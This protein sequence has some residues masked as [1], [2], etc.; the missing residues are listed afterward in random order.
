M[1]ILDVKSLLS[2]L[3]PCDISIGY[4]SAFLK[5]ENRA[6][7]S[8][9]LLD[10]LVLARDKNEFVKDLY[11]TK[12]ISSGSMYFSQ[13]FDQEVAFFADLRLS[14]SQR[15]KVGVIE[16]SRALRRMTEWDGSF[17]I[18][19]RL[20]KPVRLLRCED[21]RIERDFEFARARNFES[22]L[23]AAVIL[24]R[25]RGSDLFTSFDLLTVLVSMSYLGDIRVSF[26]EDPRKV[27]NIVA[28]QGEDLRSMY[29]PFFEKVGIRETS[30]REL[31]CFKT[32]EELWSKLP[33][34]FTRG[35]IQLVDPREA[36]IAT[37]R[38]I[39][40]RESFHQALTGLGTTGV[41]KSVKY[42][43][44]KVSKRFFYAISSIFLL[45]SLVR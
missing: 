13:F 24:A 14:S 35:A 16:T 25:P 38:S 7:E 42:L 19:G 15:C 10:L 31:Q 22:A 45:F 30:S 37:L 20:Q 39:N 33:S 40:R 26:A 3:P 5:Q 4:G 43:A 29:S 2:S 34:S 23:R 41:S 44:R 36:L 18:P 8:A 17:Y 9:S 11:R 32:N 6:P 28:G 27:R 12:L 1:E 21:A